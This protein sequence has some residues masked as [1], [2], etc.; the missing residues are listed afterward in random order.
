MSPAPPQQLGCCPS[1][2]SDV[3]RLTSFLRESNILLCRECIK[4]LSL[5]VNMWIWNH[6]NRT[7]NFKRA[8]EAP[9]FLARSVQSRPSLHSRS[10]LATPATCPT[11]QGQVPPPALPT[12]WKEAP[13]QAQPQPTRS[14]SP[15]EPP[16]LRTHAR[17]QEHSGR[18]SQG[19]LG[20]P[21]GKLKQGAGPVGPGRGGAGAGLEE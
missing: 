10:A 15:S 18:P 2:T 9:R 16:Y 4:T 5:V 6:S 13:S 20:T 7:H 12:F 14:S 1:Q 21:A 11:D 17:T 8:L 19:F 3:A